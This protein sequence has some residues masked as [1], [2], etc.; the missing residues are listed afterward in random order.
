MLAVLMLRLYLGQV[1]ASLAVKILIMELSI[2]NKY[3]Q[4]VRVYRRL[5]QISINT[6]HKISNTEAKDTAEEIFNQCYHL[7]DYFKKDKKLNRSFNV[8][9]YVNENPY[10]SL[11]ADYCNTFKHGGLDKKPRLGKNIEQ[12]NTHLFILH[13]S[14]T[15]FSNFTRLEIRVDGKSYDVFAIASECL[16]AWN[17]FLRT[18]GREDIINLV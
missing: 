16:K 18:A 4:M 2:K 6:G 17:D 1:S 14:K 13:P 11:A 15:G 12:I 5:A 9:E 3:A 7:K 8:E 10:L